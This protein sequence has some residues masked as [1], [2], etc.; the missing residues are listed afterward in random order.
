MRL[1]EFEIVPEVAVMLAEPTP[2]PLAS[3]ELEI[4]ATLGVSDDHEADAVRSC[5]LPSV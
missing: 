5:V 2:R 4:F 3:P 1:A